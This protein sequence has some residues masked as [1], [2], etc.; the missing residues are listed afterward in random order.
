MGAPAIAGAASTVSALSP[1]RS[2]HTN[3]VLPGWAKIEVPP[4]RDIAL[5]RAR[6]PTGGKAF[7][8][9]SDALSYNDSLIAR[10]GD[11]ALAVQT[12]LERC[13]AEK[14]FCGLPNCAKC[15]RFYRRYF[16]SELLQIGRSRKGRFE[17]A[18]ILLEIVNSGRLAQVKLDDAHD[19]LRKRL[20]RSAFS[21]SIIIGG[22][23]VT[24]VEKSRHWILHVHILAMGVSPGS[25]RR[26]RTLYSNDA[27]TDHGRP[28]D[29]AIATTRKRFRAVVVKKLRHPIDQCSYLLKYQTIHRPGTQRGARRARVVPLRGKPLVELVEWRMNYQLDDFLFLYGAR[30]RGGKIVPNKW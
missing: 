3:F 26:L 27:T 23:E 1:F 25:W 14:E 4:D 19:R 21:G 30:R 28:A 5:L 20:Q 9:H 6:A 2:A 16:V 11:R 15:A 22:T 29:P 10:L 13:C 8:S 24:W 18:T 12:I 17:T 7:E